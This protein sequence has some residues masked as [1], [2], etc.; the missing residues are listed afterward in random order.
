MA[1]GWLAVTAVAV[2]VAVAAVGLVSDS[3]TD[4]R[5]RA[6]SAAAVSAALAETSP[7][8]TETG[9]TPETATPNVPATTGPAGTGPT[10]PIPTVTTAPGASPGSVPAAA[11]ERN[12]TLIGGQARI[13][14]EPSGVTVVSASPNPGFTMEQKLHDGGEVEVRFRSDG[15]ESRLRA[16]W[17]NG[18]ASDIEEDD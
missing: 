4:D 8:S 12:Y 7:T 1:L 15:H 2:G 10:T 11:E 6:L 16:S 14:F 17:N 3:M 13:R 9:A 5:P 18:P